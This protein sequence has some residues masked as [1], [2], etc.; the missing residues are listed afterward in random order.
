MRTSH[1]DTCSLPIPQRKST[2]ESIQSLIFTKGNVYRAEDSHVRYMHDSLLFSIA[3]PP[4]RRLDQTGHHL[5]HVGMLT[6]LTRSKSEL[7]AESALL[8]KPLIIQR[9]RVIR[10]TRTKTDRM[11]LVLLARM[12]RT[13]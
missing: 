3:P 9:R 12:V 4:L 6:D 11:L 5:A 7:V 8:R 1:H 2:F 13:W 10:P